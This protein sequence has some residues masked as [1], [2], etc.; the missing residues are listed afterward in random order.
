MKALSLWQPWAT[1]VAIGAKQCETRSWETLYRGPI[2]IHAAKKWSRDLI[3]ICRTEPF[4]SVIEPMRPNMGGAF[5]FDDA[6]PMILPRGVI[7]AT[8]Y[9]VQCVRIDASTTP[10]DPTERAF[11]DYTPGRFRWNL[12]NIQPLSEPIPFVGRQGLFDIPDSILQSNP[13]AEGAE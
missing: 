9:L 4:R 6:L 1:L 11:G 8:A 5:Y 7:V 13:N 12:E 10:S 2:A 3:D